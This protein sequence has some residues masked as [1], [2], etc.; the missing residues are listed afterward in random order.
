MSGVLRS[1]F[2]SCAGTVDELQN[3]GGGTKAEEKAPHAEGDSET[4]KEERPLTTEE[5]RRLA[6]KMSGEFVVVPDQ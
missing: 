6:E 3:H 4:E 2:R 5:A 1:L